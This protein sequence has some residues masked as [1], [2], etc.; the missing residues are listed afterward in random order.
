VN[1]GADETVYGR[2]DRSG[3]IV[4][5][6]GRDTITGG[7][8]DDLIYAGNGSDVVNG[9]AGND[10]IFGENGPD[11]LN[12]NSDNGTTQVVTGEAVLTL[13]DDADVFDHDADG[14]V[15]A[16]DDVPNNT[17]V[18]KEGVYI[19]VDDDGH[20]TEL[21][22]DGNPVVHI[23]YSVTPTET[24]WYTLAYTQGNGLD[25]DGDS[26][27]DG[28]PPSD[29]TQAYLEEGN[30]YYYSFTYD[31]GHSTVRVD[32][33][34][35]QIEVTGNNHDDPSSVA[36]S[37][38]LPDQNWENYFDLVATESIEIVAGD[39]LIGGNGPDQ[40]T[41]DLADGP[42]NVDL[43]WDYNQGNGTYD[44]FEGDTLVFRNFPDITVDDLTSSTSQDLDG[45]GNNDLVIYF[46]ENHAIGL[47]G[48]TDIE[49][50]SIIFA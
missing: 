33:F 1:G 2:T 24:G 28:T 32:V 29:Q 30:T 9:G 36:T 47:V 16:I 26:E 27:F 19:A 22:Q 31:P 40:F 37:Q 12:G 10:I 18:S 46:S 7:N 8:L 20:P 39:Q 14:D 13:K 43:I 44:Q 42:N 25:G 17:T 3:I 49:Q 38:G 35:G 5:G 11:R 6:N 23:V 48:I 15:V 4:T 50:V 34:A 41:Y 45:D 21:D